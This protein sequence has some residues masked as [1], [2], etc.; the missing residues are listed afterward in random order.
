MYDKGPIQYCYFLYNTE[1]ALHKM[2][3]GE[4]LCQMY[5]ADAHLAVIDTEAKRKHLASLN[6]FSEIA[7]YV[8]YIIVL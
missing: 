6:I 4:K 7:V 1:L 8:K 5:D 2:D 3:D